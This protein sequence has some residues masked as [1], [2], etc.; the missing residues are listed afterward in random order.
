MIFPIS[1]TDIQDNLLSQLPRTATPVPQKTTS[2]SPT[3]PVAEGPTDSESSGMIAV[4]AG[5]GGAVGVMLIALIIII[6][7]VIVVK[8]K[9]KGKR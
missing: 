8:N 4:Y 7:V 5:V 3:P 1:S 2:F 6:P 9:C